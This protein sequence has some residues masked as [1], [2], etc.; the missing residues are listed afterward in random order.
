MSRTPILLVVFI[1]FLSACSSASL[2]VPENL[3]CESKHDPVGIAT[4]QPAFNWKNVARENHAGQSAFQILVASSPSLLKEGKTD[5]WNSGKV[6]GP[7]S[8]W[9][10]YK[11][12]DLESRSIGW[13]KVRVW[14][15]NDVASEW[16]EARFFSV[17]L[18]DPGD[19]KGDYIGMAPEKA[20]AESPW[21]RK[22]FVLEKGFDA[23]FLH[24]NSLGYHEVYVNGQKAGD[25]ILAPAESQ[26]NKRSFSLTYDLTPYLKEGKNALVLWLGFGWYKNFKDRVHNGPLVRA[27][28]EG[29]R[30]GSWE[31]I[32]KTDPGWKVSTSEYSLLDNGKFGGEILDANQIN[33]GFSLAGFDD[34]QWEQATAIRVPDHTVTPQVVELNRIKEEIRPVKIMELENEVFLVDMGKNFTGKVMINFPA[35]PGGHEVSMEYSDHLKSENQ[36]LFKSQTDKPGWKLPSDK[37]R[38]FE[39]QKD[40]YISSGEAGVFTHK[41]NYRAY[42]Y[43]KISNMPVAIRAE[44]ITGQLIHTDFKQAAE[45]SCSDD[46]L[47]EIHDMFA[48]TLKCLTLGGKIVDCPHFERLGYGGDGNASTICAQTMFDLSSLYTTWLTHWADC[49]QPDG[50]MPHTAPCYYRAGGGPYWCTFIIKAAWE[51][52][53][54]YGDRRVLETFYPYMLNWLG[55]VQS[56]S[57][58]VLLEGFPATENRHWYLG[59]WATPDGIDQKDP[60]SVDLVSNC[61]IVDSYDKMIKIAGVLHKESDLQEFISKKQELSGAVHEAFYHPE[62]ATYA[63]GVQ[64]D[65]TYPLLLGIVPDSLVEK[66][67]ESLYSETLVNRKG[68]WATGLVGLPIITEWANHNQESDLMYEMMTKKDYPGFGYMIENGATTTWEHW[69]GE[70]SRI[71][72]CYNAPGSWFYQSVGGIAPLE[73]NPGYERFLLAPRPPEALSWAKVSKE[74]AYGTIRVDW[75]KKGDQMLIEASIPTGSKAKLVLPDGVQ[76]CFIDSE[77]VE[78]NQQGAIWIDCGAYTIKYG[79]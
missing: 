44:D 79:I 68:H 63:S 52:Y 30:K 33:E 31:I 11:G 66:V 19:W 7:N 61:A 29:L 69:R 27:Q 51:T 8:V 17:G 32:Q 24:V 71:H 20:E 15:Q 16:S 6:S 65:L 74:T 53:L 1:A 78:A 67:R 70:R 22:S 59:D 9:V 76:S 5:L 26:Y 3:L 46:L 57:P 28:L 41:F 64:I 37:N 56:H 39:I 45:F 18:L 40:K 12:K 73:D 35:L 60:R 49:N 38:L 47:N 10:P 13:W 58:D 43:M 72:N 62:S 42:R 36:E 55:F 54:N 25:A 14:D 21:L 2:I 77:Q 34:T 48:Y 23:I 50:D 4:D 75:Q